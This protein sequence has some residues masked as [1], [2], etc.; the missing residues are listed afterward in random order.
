[1]VSPILSIERWKL[2]E[3]QDDRQT[4]LQYDDEKFVKALFQVARKL[5]DAP[6]LAD[7]YKELYIDAIENINAHYFGAQEVN[8]ATRGQFY[9]H[10]ETAEDQLREAVVKGVSQCNIELRSLLDAHTTVIETTTTGISKQY[11]NPQEQRR[12]SNAFE[13]TIATCTMKA[14]CEG[15]FPTL[16]S[17]YFSLNPG[18]RVAEGRERREQRLYGTEETKGVT[19]RLAESGSK[20]ITHRD[21]EELKR[22]NSE[23]NVNGH[24]VIQK[25]QT[26]YDWVVSP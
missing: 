14:V 11:P 23:S 12:V 3:R 5:I 18:E 8:A 19:Q 13:Q 10:D 21:V 2:V 1:M 15:W 9:K 25:L 7:R 20:L 6:I 22:I 24:P 17:Y 4:Y 26:E 16:Q